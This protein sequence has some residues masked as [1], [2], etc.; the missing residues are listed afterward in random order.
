M[1]PTHEER[2]DAPVEPAQPNYIAANT[3]R[4]E[5]GLNPENHYLENR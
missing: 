1:E 4:E 3:R 2:K 5:V